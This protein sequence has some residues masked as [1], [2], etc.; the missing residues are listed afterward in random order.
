MSYQIDIGRELNNIIISV[1]LTVIAIIQKEPLIFPTAN[2]FLI[3]MVF[4]KEKS[5]HHAFGMVLEYE[6]LKDDTSK[7]TKKTYIP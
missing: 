2:K 4:Q 3:T 1:L 7:D 5:L 6:Y